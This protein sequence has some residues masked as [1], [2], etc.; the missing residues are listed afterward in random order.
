MCSRKDELGM[1]PEYLRYLSIIGR[2]GETIDFHKRRLKDLAEYLKPKSITEATEKDIQEFLN[3]MSKWHSDNTVCTTL[4][5]L[6]MFFKW[7]LKKGYV[8]ENP[9]LKFSRFASTP[10]KPRCLS[11]EE[12]ERL[13]KAVKDPRDMAIIGLMLFGGLSLSETAALSAED[14]RFAGVGVFISAGRGKGRRT[15]YF[16]DPLAGILRS[17]AGINKSKYL[18]PNLYNLPLGIRGIV[19]LIMEYGHKANI[20]D[21]SSQVLRNTFCRNMLDRGMPVEDVASLA[22]YAS[23]EFLKRKFG[24]VSKRTHRRI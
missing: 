10:S 9:V 24:T 8:S 22:G 4:S 13:L 5:V 18:F 7:C 21:L 16:E 1:M 6:S 11:E 2:S 3:E 20:P 12:Q 14:I 19:F 17:W 23:P 15:V